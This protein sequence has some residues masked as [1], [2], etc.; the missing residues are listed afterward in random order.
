MVEGCKIEAKVGFSEAVTIDTTNILFIFSGSF[1][2]IEE[3]INV[4]LSKNGSIGFG[5]KVLKGEKG[6]FLLTT[7]K[8]GD[9]FG[10]MAILDEEL[11]SAT[12]EMNEDSKLLIIKRDHF[13]S[14]LL[15]K[16]QIAFALFK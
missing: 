16:P 6:S 11:R 9:F 3:I 15:S 1:A 5:S 13:Q 7:L 8:Q 10:E 2:G 4:R 12:I 14:L